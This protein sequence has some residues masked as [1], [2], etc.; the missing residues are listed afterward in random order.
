MR[1]EL[2]SPCS[3]TATTALKAGTG[4]S[5]V[6]SPLYE[7]HRKS[8]IEDLKIFRFNLFWIIRETADVGNVNLS[9]VSRRSRILYFFLHR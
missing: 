2:I 1:I 4:T 3:R 8:E 7:Q 5:S 6:T 9:G